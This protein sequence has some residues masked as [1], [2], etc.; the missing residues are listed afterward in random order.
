M[1]KFIMTWRFAGLVSYTMLVFWM[2]FYGDMATKILGTGAACIMAIIMAYRIEEL[3]AYITAL[4]KD[5]ERVTYGLKACIEG[6]EKDLDRMKSGNDGKS[7]SRASG[8]PLLTEE[9]TA[10]APDIIASD[11][12]EICLDN[13]DEDNLFR[14]SNLKEKK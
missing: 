11:D 12:R 8:I 9:G 14:R 1:R 10:S 13:D 6:L 4:E 2:V 3:E 7:G 5:A